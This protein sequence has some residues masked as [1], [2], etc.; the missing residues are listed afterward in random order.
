MAFLQ[1]LNR[2]QKTKLIFIG[3]YFI[4]NLVIMIVSFR[5][6]LNNIKFLVDV[7]KMIPYAK[8]VASLGMIFFFG[9]IIIHYIELRKVKKELNKNVKEVHVL[10]SRLYDMDEKEKTTGLKK[11]E[12]DQPENK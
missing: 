5:L 9:L 1:N 7:S 8:Y 4:F 3:L 12:S 10:K 2:F 11:E 6:S